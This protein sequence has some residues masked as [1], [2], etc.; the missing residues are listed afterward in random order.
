MEDLGR[1]RVS[2]LETES[3]DVVPSDPTVVR[4]P[5]RAGSEGDVGT[6]RDS[7]QTR[8]APGRRQVSDE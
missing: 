1:Y 4:H 2:V 8:G 5:E 3:G 6:G 7:T